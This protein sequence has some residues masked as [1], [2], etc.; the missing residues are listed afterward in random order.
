VAPF[1]TKHKYKL[2]V[3]IEN[4]HN[5]KTH[6]RKHD[7]STFAE[8]TSWGAYSLDIIQAEDLRT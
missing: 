1:L 2:H 5:K 3:A 8:D 7:V 6:A 4:C